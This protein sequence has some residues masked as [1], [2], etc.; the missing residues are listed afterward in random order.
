MKRVMLMP[1]KVR[2][3]FVPSDKK[4][5]SSE[6]LVILRSAQRDIVFLLN[7]GYGAER[8]IRFVGD[9]YQLSSRQRMALFRAAASESSLRARLARQQKNS[10]RGETL[11][12]DGFN[13]VIPLEIALS[14]GTLLL[15]MDGTVRDL[16]GL[17]GTY[18][19]IDK[20]DEAINMIGHAIK[21]RGATAAVFYFDSPVSNAG[22]LAQRVREVLSG[23][24]F[25]VSAYAEP[26]VDKVL[27]GK[28]NVVSGDSVIIS[29]CK[30]W[31]N[32][33]REILADEI[34]DYPFADL[35]KP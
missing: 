22:R 5:F 14:G 21:K 4:E 8:S 17:H 27:S 19:L 20:T 23:F 3:G 33:T 25:S 9:H 12:I 26:H 11:H 13:I 7:R 10:V 15:C 1:E 24:P 32:L 28:S 2:R 16:A 18:R 6:S 35:S 31:I 29:H 34:P 30:S